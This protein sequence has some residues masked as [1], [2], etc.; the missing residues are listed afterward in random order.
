MT[1][2][3]SSKQYAAMVPCAYCGLF[4][5]A[6]SRIDQLTA[7]NL[8]KRERERCGR[9]RRALGLPDAGSPPE[10]PEVDAK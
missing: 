3:L 9:T 2:L 10:R 8:A 1:S 4:H 6:T 7:S 5:R